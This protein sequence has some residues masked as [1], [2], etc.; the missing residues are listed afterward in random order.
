MSYIHKVCT[1]VLKVS[2]SL[3]QLGPSQMLTHHPFRSLLIGVVVKHYR[4]YFRSE[5]VS[6]CAQP[7]V[8]SQLR[9]Y[10]VFSNP[11]IG[12]AAALALLGLL[13]T[14]QMYLLLISTEWYKIIA[15]IS[16]M[17]INV[18]SIFRLVKAL[19]VMTKIYKTKK[20]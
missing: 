1:R 2:S 5:S 18:S 6:N 20:R 10:I 19:V 13:L 11:K 9:Y 3:D 14:A 8:S 7:G 12:F 16:M 4:G 17:L 15:M